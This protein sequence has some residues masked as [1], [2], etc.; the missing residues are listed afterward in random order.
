MFCW[1]LLKYRSFITSI[2]NVLLTQYQ[3]MLFNFNALFFPHFQHIY[4]LPSIYLTWKLCGS[5]YFVCVSYDLLVTVPL[6]KAV[7]SDVCSWDQ[8]MLMLQM[9]NKCNLLTK[10]QW[11]LLIVYFL[12]LIIPWLWDRCFRRKCIEQLEN[13]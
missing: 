7:L 4:T 2:N 3:N 8:E 13:I 9:I 1:L 12:T 5:N 6:I 11:V 10:L